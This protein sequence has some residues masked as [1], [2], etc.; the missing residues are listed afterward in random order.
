MSEFSYTRDFGPLPADSQIELIETVGESRLFRI[1]KARKGTKYVILKT[2]V[3]ADAMS[4]EML[5][6]EYELACDLNHPCIART[7]GFEETTPVGPAIVMEYVEGVNLNEFIASNPSQSRRRA[8]LQDILDGVDYLHHRGILH[9]DLKPENIL[10][11]RTGA[12]RI[13]DFGLSASSDSIY[14]GCLGGTDGYTAPEILR[15]DGPAGPASDIYAIGRLMALLFG[16]RAYR[17]TIRAC[18]AA[19]PAQRPQDIRALRQRILRSDRMPRLVAA[20][21]AVLLAAGVLALLAAR[22]QAGLEHR[23]EER[24]DSLERVQTKR[25][26][27]RAVS[28]SNERADSLE[29]VRTKRIETLR[30]SFEG[31]FEPACRKTL[32]QIRQQQYR[33]AAQVLTAPYY[34]EAVPRFDSVCR[35]YPMHTDGSIPDELTLVGEVFNACRQRLDSATNSLPSIMSLPAAQRDSVQQIINQLTLRLFPEE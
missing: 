14:R 6:R 19:D 18:T 16:G 34:Q 2:P 20:M 1:C 5:R 25:I 11:T 9:N 4:V 29:R 31:L 30:R 32:E 24:A 13:L 12:A 15:G 23:I 17:R 35:C 33:E 3:A 10:V 7:L 22:Q 21:A 27:E 8:L 26:E 28:Y